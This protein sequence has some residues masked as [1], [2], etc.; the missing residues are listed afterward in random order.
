MKDLIIIG[1]GGFGREVSWLVKRINEVCPQ[2]NL[3]GFLDD[4]QIIQSKNIDKYNIISKV[5]DIVNYPD[6]YVVCCVADAGVR[7]MLVERVKSNPFATLVD[8][9]AIVSAEVEIG[10]GSVICAGAVITVD[11]KIGKHNIIDVNST[12]GHDAVLEDFVTLYPSVNVSG[13][14]LIK[15]GV[16]LGTGT[17]V[18]QG[19]S[20]GKNAIVGAGAVVIRDLPDDC[21]AVG[22]PA[23]VIKIN[24]K[25]C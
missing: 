6:A 14:T 20:I 12:V 15:S 11:I 21:T 22:V 2:W 7:K 17:Q 10:E 9:S 4:N 19:L 23:K 8:P 1:A 5:D 18:L 24:E 25:K 13:N 3:L 16:E